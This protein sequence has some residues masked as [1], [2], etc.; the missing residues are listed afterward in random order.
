[1][2][3]SSHFSLKQN[4]SKQ[5]KPFLI[6][7]RNPWVISKATLTWIHFHH[8]KARSFHMIRQRP[9]SELELGQRALR[10]ANPLS[11][12]SYPSILQAVTPKQTQPIFS[13]SL[14]HLKVLKSM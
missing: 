1:M 4:D 6:I 11:C 12:K 5:G 7:I 8:F 3:V 13:S 14:F 2:S 10:H 9:E